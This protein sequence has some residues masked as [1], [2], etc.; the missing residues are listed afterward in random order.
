MDAHLLRF[1]DVS[2][3]MLSLYLLLSLLLTA[4]VVVI[5]RIMKT[6]T[7][8]IAMVSATTVA[9]L[10]C[11]S[12]PVYAFVVRSTVKSV[13]QSPRNANTA[14]LNQRSRRVLSA[15]QRRCTSMQSGMTQATSEIG[16][17]SHCLWCV[18]C[19][20]ICV[21]VSCAAARVLLHTDSTVDVS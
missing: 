3:S 14:A 4:V 11:L 16:I 19:R 15:G 7:T 13:Q 12:S 6:S 9:V 10:A 17:W 18:G 1:H 8:S 2:P 5:H 21:E 20:G